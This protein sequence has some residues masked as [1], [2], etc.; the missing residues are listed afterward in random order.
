HRE[1]KRSSYFSEQSQ[2]VNL[3]FGEGDAGHVWAEG[4]PRLNGQQ[5]LTFAL[6]GAGTINGVISLVNTSLTILSAADRHLL[7]II[8][9]QLGAFISLDGIA[10]R[11]QHLEERSHRLAGKLN[12]SEQELRECKARLSRAH[13]ES[14]QEALGNYRLFNRLSR[15]IRTPLS[16][17]ISI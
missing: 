17:I 9:T 6:F 1:G 2:A 12:G 7:N 8:A 16:G 10:V 11:A 14:V 15:E 13:E 4:E 3:R 5:A